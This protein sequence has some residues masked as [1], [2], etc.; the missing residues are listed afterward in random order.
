MIDGALTNTK[1]NNIN[2]NDFNSNNEINENNKNEQNI[3]NDINN[4]DVKPLIKTENNFLILGY[5]QKM[6][7]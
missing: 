5:L 4:Q 1:R 6:D 3:L 2:N 7:Q